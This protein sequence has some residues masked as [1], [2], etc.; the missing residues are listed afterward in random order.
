METVGGSNGVGDYGGGESDLVALVIVVL[1]VVLMVLA[2]TPGVFVGSSS[3]K[4]MTRQK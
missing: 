2:G 1:V 3:M 4:N